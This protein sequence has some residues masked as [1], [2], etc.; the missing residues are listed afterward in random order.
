MELVEKL[1]YLGF[2]L[3]NFSLS[4]A[5]R[6]AEKPRRFTTADGL[7]AHWQETWPE[8]TETLQ[9]WQD[10]NR[11]CTNGTA[12]Q[13]P[14]WQYATA[15]PFI[16][17]G[18]YRLLTISNDDQ[19]VGTLPLQLSRTG[20]LET[21]GSMISDYI[22][23]LVLPQKSAIIW[24]A[25]CQALSR[26]PGLDPDRVILNNC[27]LDHVNVDA[28][29]RSANDHGFVVDIEQIATAARVP[30]ARSW[31]DYLASLGGHDRKELRRKM[32]NAQT[33][34]GAELVVSQKGENIQWALDKTFEFMN[35]S[36][37]AKAI[38]ARWTYR[39]IFRRVA[40]EMVRSGRLCVYML[41]LE[42]KEAAGLISFNS[43]EGPMLW[44]AGFDPAMSKLSPGMVLM[45]MAIQRAIG[46][47]AKYFDLL[48]GM[49]R[50]KHELGAVDAPVHRITLRAR[51][52]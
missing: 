18:R 42:G 26:V 21:P 28:L 34:A 27:R 23:P 35:L 30:L 50:Y 37:G 10:L 46:D 16:R 39:P 8:N 20:V 12:F 33:K 44:A 24:S 52:R 51:G 9:K 15:R 6:G 7:T 1:S 43:K 41:R 11:R 22:E 36:G 40:G 49:S 5:F 38:K 19:I 29:H 47:G 31:D 45:G 17:A 48:R 13:T 14:A 32:R 4:G 3:P 2:V 25:I